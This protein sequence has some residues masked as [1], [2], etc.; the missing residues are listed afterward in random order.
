MRDGVVH[1]KNVQIVDFRHFRHARRQCQIV[2]RILKQGILRDCD[3][4]KEYPRLL[5]VQTDRLLISNEMHFMATLRQLDPE[6]RAHNSAATVC[7]ITSDSD[8]HL[9]ISLR[10]KPLTKHSFALISLGL[11]RPARRS[12]ASRTSEKMVGSLMN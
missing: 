6:F 1:M 5:S 10:S 7:G 3:F 12:R 4:V 8:F 9:F 11:L 2:W